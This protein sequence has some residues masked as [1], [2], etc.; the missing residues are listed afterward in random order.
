MT[1]INPGPGFR[2]LDDQEHV[3][4]SDEWHDS[5]SNTWK[6]CDWTNPMRLHRAAV[7]EPVRRKVA[8]RPPSSDLRPPTSAR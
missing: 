4:P 7:D 6:P 3:Q 5:L 8:V 2:L 1:T